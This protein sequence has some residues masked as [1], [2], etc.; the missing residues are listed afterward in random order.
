M[1]E[2]IADLT[3][4]ATTGYNNDGSNGSRAYKNVSPKTVDTTEISN[5]VDVNSKYVRSPAITNNAEKE[6]EMVIPVSAGNESKDKHTSGGNSGLGKRKVRVTEGRRVDGYC[7]ESEGSSDSGS[8]SDSESS[9]GSE[10]ESESENERENER[11]KVETKKYRKRPAP[12]AAAAATDVKTPASRQE[13]AKRVNTLSDSD[14]DSEPEPEVVVNSDDDDNDTDNDD[15]NDDGPSKPKRKMSEEA[16]EFASFMIQL[17]K[18]KREMEEKMRVRLSEF[19]KENSSKMAE[20]KEEN[21]SEMA[22]LRN[23]VESYCQTLVEQQQKHISES[24]K[25]SGVINS[26]GTLMPPP[27]SP[28][29]RSVAASSSAEATSAKKKVMGKNLTVAAFL[30]HLF[31]MDPNPIPF[32]NKLLPVPDLK[33][34]GPYSDLPAYFMAPSGDP[35]L[36]K[37]DLRILSETEF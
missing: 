35:G 18:L 22:D 12:T 7:S 17:E 1:F 10:S 36:K 29:P 20:F 2:E 4:T 33:Q 28:A 15:D 23:N 30:K 5:S 19:R 32:K 13:S 25:H 3:G 8:S 26:N 6:P 24:S 37:L 9:S 11:E 34:E 16:G 27:A 21:R 14:S 31:N